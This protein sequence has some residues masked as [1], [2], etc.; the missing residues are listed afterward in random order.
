M[1]P[2]KRH[3]NT[4]L[5][6]KTL[7]GASQLPFSIH[8]LSTFIKYSNVE[9]RLK[10][11]DD[12]TLSEMDILLVEQELAGATVIKKKDRES[13]ILKKMERY[14]A[15]I[16]FRSSNVLGLKLFDV[17]LYDE[18][19]LLFIDSDVF[20]LRPFS[21]PILSQ[22][23]PVFMQDV[24]NA[25]SFD[26]FDFIQVKHAIFPRINTGMISFPRNL[27]RLDLIEELLKG[28][29]KP[30]RV[31]KFSYGWI[32]QTIWAFLAGLKEFVFYFNS[33][34]FIIPTNKL[35]LDTDTIAIHLV[36]NRRWMYNDVKNSHLFVPQNETE[37]HFDY[38]EQKLTKLAFFKER[39]VTM[40]KRYKA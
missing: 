36:S 40:L 23:G 12:G 16:A 37:I 27:Y 15:C 18:D 30:E 8:C 34:Q 22:E 5:F 29:C 39:F 9:I 31:T 33:Q 20:F 32:E 2:N 3:I 14:P 10:I 24:M 13:L 1:D 25:Y 6:F 28:I 21:W 19:N 4:P 35:I 38:I 11:F 26:P 17:M 7:I